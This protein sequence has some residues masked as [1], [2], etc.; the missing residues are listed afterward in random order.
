[1]L[2]FI[3]GLLVSVLIVVIEIYL[4]QK[5]NG[6][7]RKIQQLT[8]IKQKGFIVDQPTDKQEAINNLFKENDEF[9]IETQIDELL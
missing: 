8:E 3:A 4:T 6:I 9:G 7:I 1:M 2:Y 5:N